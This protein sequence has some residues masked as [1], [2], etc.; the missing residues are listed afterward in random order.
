[1]NTLKSSDHAEPP[2]AEASR[3]GASA[4]H[5]AHES[6]TTA[7]KASVARY[8][9]SSLWRSI[10]QIANT[11]VPYAGLWCLMY[12]TLPIS[13]WLTL[14]LA[15]L[16]GAFLVR[17]FILFHDCGHGS[18]FKSQTANEVVGM[19][20]GLLTFTPYHHWRREHATHHATSGDLDRRGT[21]DL[22]TMTVREYLES[23]RSKRFAYRLARN[24]FILF[25]AAPL[26]LL[27]VKNRIPKSDAGPLERRW[28]LGTDLA[29]LGMAF[30]LSAIFGFKAYLIIQFT[31]LLVA[32][33]AGFWLFYVQH[34]FEG[35]YWAHGADWDYTAAA[36]QGSSFYKLPRVL[37]WFTG[38][39]G[40]HHL[41]HLSARIPN[42][43]L[44]KCHNADPLFRNVPPITLFASL[45]SLS[46]RLWDEQRQRLVGYDHLRMLRRQQNEASEC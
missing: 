20:T 35:G 42:Y 29:L 36:L 9:H 23:S 45:K 5:G 40:Y 31:A 30:G 28:V 34:Q 1:M 4:I 7:W 17:M 44:E 24:P 18:F 32:G 38:S 10:W 25:I 6:D 2:S 37:Q 26:F 3:G 12:F 16:A 41:H 8:Q 22:W 14:P 21:G 15:V 19:I 43:H 11:V 27:L 39:I 13:W 46:F 33:A